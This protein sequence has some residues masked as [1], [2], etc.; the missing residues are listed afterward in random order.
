MGVNLGADPIRLLLGDRPPIAPI[1]GRT[2]LVIVDLHVNDAHPE[3]AIARM[4]RRRGLEELFRPYYQAVEERVLPNVSRLLAAARRRGLEVVYLVTCQPPDA[5]ASRGQEGRTRSVP[6]ATPGSPEAQVLPAIA[7][8]P[9]EVVVTKHTSGPF[10]SSSL[11]RTL[12][13]L[14]VHTLVVG[15]VATHRCV[16]LTVRDAADR[17][18]LVMLVGDACADFTAELHQDAL[19]RMDDGAMTEV[20]STEE[21]LRRIEE[22]PRPD[23]D[24]RAIQS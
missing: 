24:G 14:G 21:A 3:G 19:R 10:N 12:R 22:A 1:V 15:G 2:A 17:G 16:E 11:D 18:Y 5:A 20:V 23:P 13:E 4:A 6:V 7:P 8:Q 9:G